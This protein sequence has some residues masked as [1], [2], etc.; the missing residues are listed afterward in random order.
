MDEE[1][2][3]EELDSAEL[4][5]DFRARDDY[6]AYLVE[7]RAAQVGLSWAHYQ[8]ALQ[9]VRLHAAPFSQEQWRE[10]T[11]MER[12]EVLGAYSLAAERG[13]TPPAVIESANAR[14]GTW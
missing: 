7:Q 5:A 10:M 13:Y 8:E 3:L 9:G 14:W 1:L 12:K 11:L 6:D 2:E 4:F